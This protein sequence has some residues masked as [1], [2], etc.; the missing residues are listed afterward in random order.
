M[1]RN[2]I[3]NISPLSLAPYLAAIVMVLLP[4]Y[5]ADHDMWD[6]VMIQ[7]AMI[8]NDLSGLKTFLFSSG[9]IFMYWQFF[10]LHKIALFFDINDRIPQFL[11]VAISLFVLINE[12]MCLAKNQ[13]RLPKFWVMTTAFLILTFP[14]WS[15][16]LSSALIYQFSSVA[17]GM[18]GVR[19]FHSNNKIHNTIGMMLICFSLGYQAIW[20]FLSALSYLYDTAKSIEHGKGWRPSFRTVVIFLATIASVFMFHTILLTD[21]LFTNYAAVDLFSIYGIEKSIVGLFKYSTFLYLPVIGLVSMAGLT[22]LLDKRSKFTLSISPIVNQ[23]RLFIVIAFL[24]LSSIAPFIGTGKATYPLQGFDW[25]G[26]HSFVLSPVLALFT[27][28]V[29]YYFCKMLNISERLMIPICSLVVVLIILIQLSLQ[30]YAIYIKYIRQYFE[31]DLIS[32]LSENEINL[33]PGMVRIKG[34][35]FPGPDMRPYESNYLL[36]RATGKTDW[37]SQIFEESAVETGKPDYLNIPAYQKVYMT[38][39]PDSSCSTT[40]TIAVQGYRIRTRD[41]IK[42]IFKPSP[43]RSISLVDHDEKCD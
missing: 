24:A 14:M 16:L 30:S 39:Q 6:G 18:M 37:Y 13:L 31:Q 43:P 36:F 23:R 21:G 1:I 20:V 40:I 5:F 12:C 28:Y 8:I 10:A 35:G 27:S 11:L 19:L 41:R 7:Y 38:S 4:I 2:I 22:L 3:K 25:M 26:R 32:F 29:L 33:K 15:L 34:T 17:L 9:W 42:N